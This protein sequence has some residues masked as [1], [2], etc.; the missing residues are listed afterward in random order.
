MT[1]RACGSR[2]GVFV[3]VACALVAAS[4]FLPLRFS[5][6]MT[7]HPSVT[8]S[9]TVNDLGALLD[10]KSA[11]EQ[12]QIISA[13]ADLQRPI[14]GT[15]TLTSDDGAVYFVVGANGSSERLA[16]KKGRLQ[17]TTYNRSD[18]RHAKQICRG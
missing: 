6:L 11:D 4:F 10:G 16:L 7:T 14:T 9:T 1:K 15:K 13:F 2:V 12:A 5:R 18:H 17:Q 3:A 8:S